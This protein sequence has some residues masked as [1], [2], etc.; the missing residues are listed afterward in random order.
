MTLKTH[1]ICLDFGQRN[2]YE[3]YVQSWHWVNIFY[4]MTLFKVNPFHATCLIL[5]PLKTL[6]TCF[7]DVFRGY[8]KSSSMR[9]V[10]EERQRHF[11][12]DKYFGMSCFVLDYWFKNT[13]QSICESLSRRQR[14]VFTFYLTFIA[15]FLF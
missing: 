8:K 12:A 13:I 5:Y 10:I 4:H 3:K 14:K 7:S 15:V 1:C 9:W 2:H 11:V 6:E